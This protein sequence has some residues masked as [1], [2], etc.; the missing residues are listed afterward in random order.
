MEVSLG[1]STI[2]QARP[3]S[4]EKVLNITQNHIFVDVL[5][6]FDLLGVGQICCCCSYWSFVVCFDFWFFCYCVDFS[7][8][9]FCLFLLSSS[10]SEIERKRENTKLGEYSSVRIRE[11]LGKEKN[12]FKK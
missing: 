4:Q 8:C 3:Y 6:C 1:T 5:S 9:C 7:C 11:G 2:L 12:D 10:D